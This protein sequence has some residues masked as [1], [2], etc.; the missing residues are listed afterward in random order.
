MSLVFQYRR[1]RSR[2]AVPS[3]GGSRFRYRPLIRV[4]LVG[5]AAT[6]VGD[7]LLDT[8]ADD[9]VFSES[10]AEHIGLDLSNAPSGELSGVGASVGVVRYAQVRLRVTDGHEFREWPAWVGFTAARLKQPLLGYAGFLHFFTAIFRGDR[11]EVIL[12][13][14]A[15]YP[16]S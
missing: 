7:G 10:A 8:G 3:L 4:S 14:N 6:Y 11:R 15:D 12:E 5:P 1:L 13:V 2:Y 9:T 16:G